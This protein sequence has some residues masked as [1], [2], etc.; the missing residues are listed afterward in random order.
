MAVVNIVA[1]IIN[2]AMLVGGH[3]KLGKI[4]KISGR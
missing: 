3:E 2:R 4:A 1:V